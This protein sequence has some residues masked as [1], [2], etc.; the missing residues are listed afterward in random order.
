MIGP[1]RS[2]QPPAFNRRARTAGGGG[3]PETHSRLASWLWRGAEGPD[4][5]GVVCRR[6]RGGAAF[7]SAPARPASGTTPMPSWREIPFLLKAGM[8]KLT[9]N[10]PRGLR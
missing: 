1:L 3:F 2:K 7:P 10:K 9:P 6:R 4:R 8:Q 5:G